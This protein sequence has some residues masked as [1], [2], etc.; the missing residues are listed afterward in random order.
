MN[1]SRP[2]RIKAHLLICFISLV[3]IRLIQKRT[4]FKHS[5]EKLIEAMNNVSCSHEGGNLY[6]F[7]YRSNV[8]DD[9]AEAFG[10][11][12]SKLRLTRAEIK[13]NIGNAKKL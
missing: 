3:I 13:K 12:F 1:V 9:L 5:I 7:D 10:M 8:T 11:D 6:L 2:D 4:G